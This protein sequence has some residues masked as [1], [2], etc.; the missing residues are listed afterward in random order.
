M[1]LTAEARDLGLIFLPAK[2]VVAAGSAQ[3]RL[4]VHGAQRRPPRAVPQARH[5]RNFGHELHGPRA[6]RKVEKKR[7]KPARERKHRLLMLRRA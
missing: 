3:V 5:M 1:V 7:M 2:S 6:L 4:V